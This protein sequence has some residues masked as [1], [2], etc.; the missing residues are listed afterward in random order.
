MQNC[1]GLPNVQAKVFPGDR[2]R[3]TRARGGGHE[4]LS[5]AAPSKRSRRP[6]QGGG[7]ANAPSEPVGDDQ[8]AAGG[9]HE[10]VADVFCA[11]KDAPYY[12][13]SWLR[14]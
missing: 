4:R 5:P 12:V 3:L 14:V 6:G 13:H 1:E 10:V 7:A 8:A 11:L 2:V 9:D